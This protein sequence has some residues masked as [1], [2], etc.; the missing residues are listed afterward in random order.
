MNSQDI[1]D[2]D[3]LIELRTEFAG[4]RDDLKNMS[5]WV[6]KLIDDHEKRLRRLEW[7]GAVA[8]G[9]LYIINFILGFV[10]LKK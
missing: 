7:M 4:M 8:V 3:L 6:N 1:T 10:A 9:G 2:H 5:I